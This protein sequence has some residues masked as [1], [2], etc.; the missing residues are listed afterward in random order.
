MERQHFTKEKRHGVLAQNYRSRT[1]R[2]N[3]CKFLPILQGFA[4]Q[5]SGFAISMSC[6]GP[7]YLTPGPQD[8]ATVVGAG[9]I[10][11]CERSFSCAFSCGRGAPEGSSGIS[12]DEKKGEMTKPSLTITEGESLCNSCSQFNSYSKRPPCRMENTLE[13]SEVVEI[14]EVYKRPRLIS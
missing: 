11:H 12:R 14:R 2:E 10:S 6:L 13:I 4:R 7:I 8:V 5:F 3:K 9:C 1:L